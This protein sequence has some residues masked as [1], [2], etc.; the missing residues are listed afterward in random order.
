MRTFLDHNRTF[1]NKKIDSNNHWA[2]IKNE[3]I[4]S[5]SSGVK[6]SFVD[7]MKD[8]SFMLSHWSKILNNS[9][10]YI[11]E[12]F[13]LP[14]KIKQKNFETSESLSFEILHNFSNQYLIEPHIFYLCLAENSLFSEKLGIFYPRNLPNKRISIDSFIKKPYFI[15]LLS[16]ELLK[17]FKR[18]NKNN[19]LIFEEAIRENYEMNLI[20]INEN[21]KKKIAIFFEVKSN[22]SLLIKYIVGDKTNLDLKNS[23]LDFCNLYFFLKL[24]KTIS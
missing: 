17:D 7:Q 2:K 3:F 14:W 22:K 10:I 12:V 23:L 8:L 21:T 13:C 19:A 1:L 9:K 15:C 16:F 11:L 4:G 5:S 18:I 6:I 20:I 24:N